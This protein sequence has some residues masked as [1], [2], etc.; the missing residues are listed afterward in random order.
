MM[1]AYLA[2]KVNLGHWVSLAPQTDR[3][4]MSGHSVVRVEKQGPENSFYPL[5]VSE[6]NTD[7]SCLERLML[8]GIQNLGVKDDFGRSL[9]RREG[10]ALHGARL[11]LWSKAIFTFHK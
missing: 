4:T 3:E 7:I 11:L 10:L 8:C 1:M 6:R 2:G 9:S 5:V